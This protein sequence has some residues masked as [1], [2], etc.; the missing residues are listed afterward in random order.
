MATAE[1]KADFYYEHT[2]ERLREIKNDSNIIRTHAKWALSILVAIALGLASFVFTDIGELHIIYKELS[3]P[4]LL[5]KVFAGALFIGYS[6]LIMIFIPWLL[7]SAKDI[8]NNEDKKFVILSK[9][10]EVEILKGRVEK[11]AKK[12]LAI[13]KLFKALLVASVVLPL[14]AAA[15][16]T[17]LTYFA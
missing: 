8:D 15:I 14:V 10:Q 11:Y 9:T 3:K 5:I 12:L 7:W 17:Y 6:L 2:A 13:D 1:N 4:D 16:A